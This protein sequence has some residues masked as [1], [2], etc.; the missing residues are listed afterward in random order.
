[1]NIK[2]QLIRKLFG[3]QCS[4]YE[5]ELLFEIL[6]QDQEESA[7][8]V[9]MELF[10]QLGKTPDLDP[11]VSNEILEK[12]R[13]VTRKEEKDGKIIPI[14]AKKFRS[15]RGI[16]AAVVALMVTSWILTYWIQPRAI[17]VESTFDQMHEIVLPD[18]SLVTLNGNSKIEYFPEWTEGQLRK[19]KLWGEAFFKVEKK[20]A[21]NAK[22]QVIT[23]DLT[24]EVFG[25][26]FNVNTRQESSEVF[27]KEGE[28]RLRLKNSDTPEIRLQPGEVITYSYKKKLLVEP[29]Q[30]DQVLEISWKDG[31]LTFKDT[32]LIKI[33]EELFATSNFEFE[34][35]DKSL[36]PREFSVTL[37]N[38]DIEKALE[39]LNLNVKAEIIKKGNK[40]VF[41]EK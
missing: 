12:I 32:P 17:I 39:L 25:T 38:K 2:E 9:M 21:S 16:A 19:V 13:K 37:D 27:L 6:Q 29:Q 35:K 8:E 7:P 24:V 3:K 30:V 36:E 20:P 31:Y 11:A 28:V 4:R 22:F 1:M 10:E 5:L 41:R 26:A 33:L 15:W 18:G 40:F 14:K 34:I 23:E